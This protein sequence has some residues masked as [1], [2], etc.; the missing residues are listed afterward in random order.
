MFWKLLLEPSK[1]AM[2]MTLKLK[3]DKEFI[4]LQT[5]DK[6]VLIG[7]KSM[8]DFQKGAGYLQTQ[9]QMGEFFSIL[10]VKAYQALVLSSN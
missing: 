1:K 9:P 7:W 10:N 6:V 4:D 8:E 5:G 3:F 2:K